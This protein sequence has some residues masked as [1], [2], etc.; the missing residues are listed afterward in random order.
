MGNN[1]KKTGGQFA[2][3]YNYLNLSVLFGRGVQAGS[4]AVTGPVA[5][6]LAITH[7]LAIA[8]TLAF[9]KSSSAILTHSGLAVTGSITVGLIFLYVLVDGVGLFLG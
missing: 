8:H 6:P 9:A 5:K 4:V 2:L 7:T 1:K 3:L